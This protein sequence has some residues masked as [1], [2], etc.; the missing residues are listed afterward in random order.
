MIAYCKSA[1]QWNQEKRAADYHLEADVSRETTYG[2][3]CLEIGVQDERSLEKQL[4]RVEVNIK[5]DAIIPDQNEHHCVVWSLRT[6]I[7]LFKSIYL[8]ATRA[9]LCIVRKVIV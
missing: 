4:T 8:C 7:Q 1:Q 2:V 6:F 9:K 5:V 3:G